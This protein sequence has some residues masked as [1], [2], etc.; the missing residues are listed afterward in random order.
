MAKKPNYFQNVANELNDVIKAYR[1]TTEMSNTPGPGTDAK[2][3]RLAA[4]TRKE[5]GQLVGSI[6]MGAR[7][8]SKGK[9]VK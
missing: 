7:Y 9:R 8:N 4:K 2:A 5:A 3:N 1:D 6:L